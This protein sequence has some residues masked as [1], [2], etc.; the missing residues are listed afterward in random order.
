MALAGN[1]SYLGDRGRRILVRGQSSKSVEALS[2]K[3]TETRLS[4]S[5]L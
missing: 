5:C 2:K 3:Q 1:P 4:G